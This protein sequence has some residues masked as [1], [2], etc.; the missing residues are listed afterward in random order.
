MSNNAYTATGYGNSRVSP[1]GFDVTATSKATATSSISLE[2]AQNIANEIA[3]QIAHD[4]AMTDANVINQSI[5]L[6]QN[7]NKL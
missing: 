7:Q 2:D 3:N 5:I 1:F 6:N 4:N